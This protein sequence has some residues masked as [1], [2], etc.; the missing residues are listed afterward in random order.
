MNQVDNSYDK[1]VIDIVSE[2]FSNDDETPA[3]TWWDNIV[4]NDSSYGLYC[5]GE[6]S[7]TNIINNFVYKSEIDEY[8]SR[9]PCWQ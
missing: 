3:S 2:N 7:N 5:G 8:K 6:N 4:N 9:L 1:N